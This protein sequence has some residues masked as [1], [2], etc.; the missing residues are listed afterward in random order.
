[1]R[2][3]TGFTLMELMIVIA[4]IG[5]LVG[6]A[7]PG[8]I[9]WLPNYRLRAAADDLRSNFQKAKLAAIKGNSTCAITFNQ[10]IDGQP[11]DYVVFI[12]AD[13]D[14]EY[15]PNAAADGVDNDADGTTDEPDEI[16]SVI[17]RVRLAN[18][19]GV[20]FDTTQGGG[21]G[22]FFADNDDGLPAIGFRSNGLPRNNAGG[23]GAGTV[24]LKNT[25]ARTKT[26]VIS[27][28]GNIRIP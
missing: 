18:Y 8:I 20:S 14:L 23:F 27:L 2:R 1:M 6:I 3:N 10:P 5:I 25:K 15:D 13:D 7:V 21:D 11:Y 16:E 9:G 26:V 4:V 22:L 12:D 19:P 17:A 24:F 28:A